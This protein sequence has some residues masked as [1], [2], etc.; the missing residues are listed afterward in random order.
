MLHESLVQYPQNSP[1]SANNRDNND[2]DAIHN[3]QVHQIHT[4]NAH[5]KTLQ[6][7]LQNSFFADY[8][9]IRSR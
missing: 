4:Q 9:A 1:H 2:M 5:T 6:N 3:K 7:V 8:D